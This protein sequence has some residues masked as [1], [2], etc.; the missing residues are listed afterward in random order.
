MIMV[1]MLIMVMAAMAGMGTAI[2]ITLMKTM[3]ASSL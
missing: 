2:R 1:L 3:T